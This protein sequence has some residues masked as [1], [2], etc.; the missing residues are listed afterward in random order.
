MNDIF[1][2]PVQNP[3]PGRRKIALL[4]GVAG[5]WVLYALKKAAAMLIYLHFMR[6]GAEDSSAQAKTVIVKTV[7]DKVEKESG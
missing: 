3:T 1:Q 4:S 2:K 5:I 6:E 7:M